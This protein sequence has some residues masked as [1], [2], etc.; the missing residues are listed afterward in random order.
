MSVVLI[1]THYSS[2]SV[3]VTTPTESTRYSNANYLRWS[4]QTC[5]HPHQLVETHQ[6]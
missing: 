5:E 6:V 4:M 2:L 1:S 3:N